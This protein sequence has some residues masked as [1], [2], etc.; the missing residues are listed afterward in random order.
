MPETSKMPKQS[1]RDDR[2]GT[3][4]DPNIAL[5]R[6]I[7]FKKGH[8]AM[9]AHEQMKQALFYVAGRAPAGVMRIGSSN[10]FAR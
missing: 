8:A 3:A 7:D 9:P 2:S 1:D 10:G 5:G 6:I 4:K